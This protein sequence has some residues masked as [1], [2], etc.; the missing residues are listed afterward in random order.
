ME[1]AKIICSGEKLAYVSSQHDFYSIFKSNL[2]KLLTLSTC[3]KYTV[4]VCTKSTFVVVFRA[5]TPL[6]SVTG[7]VCTMNNFS[8]DGNYF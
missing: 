7:T 5:L 6:S 2:V 1:S 8:C 4:G 3:R